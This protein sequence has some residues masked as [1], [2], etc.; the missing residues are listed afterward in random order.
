MFEIMLTLVQK[1]SI[2]SVMVKFETSVKR[3]FSFSNKG[4]LVSGT[5]TLS[6]SCVGTGPLQST[7]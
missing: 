5:S 2:P 6:G 1:A 7:P 4:Q 3:W